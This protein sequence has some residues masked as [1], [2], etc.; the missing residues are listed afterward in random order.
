M[1]NPYFGTVCVSTAPM[2]FGHRRRHTL[3]MTVK[4]GQVMCVD[5]VQWE[6]F[7]DHAVQDNVPYPDKIAWSAEGWKYYSGIDEK[8]GSIDDAP[9]HARE[10][11][12]ILESRR[13]KSPP[14]PV[15]VEPPKALPATDLAADETALV[16]VNEADADL[17]ARNRQLE[18]QI[19]LHTM[20]E[21]IGFWSAV[22]VGFLVWCFW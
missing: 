12:A 5:A 13:P 14:A 11:A 22:V 21:S 9:R 20:C 3:V 8:W 16:H 15:V 6:V 19:A 18:R 2:D 7:A 17:V 1:V 10:V 4:L